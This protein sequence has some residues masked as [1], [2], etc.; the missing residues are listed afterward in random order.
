MSDTGICPSCGTPLPADAPEGLCPPCLFR[1]GAASDVADARLTTSGGPGFAPPQPEQLAARFP[2][3]EISALIGHGGMGAV[4]RALHRKLDRPVALKIL[5]PEIGRDPAFAERFVR[6]ARALARLNHPCIVTVHDF[7][8]SEGLYYF[9]MEFVEGRNLRGLLA[10]GQVEPAL[11]LRIIGQICD[12]LSYAHRCGVVHRDIKPENVL[13]D[14]G[15]HVKIADFGLAK[16]L[17]Y[18]AAETSLTATHQVMGTPHYMAPEQIESPG[19]VDQRA[20]IY[21]LGVVFYEMLTGHL[22]L[23]RFEPPSQNAEVG[24]EVDRVVLKTLERQPHKRYQ[25]ASEVKGEVD[26]IGTAAPPAPK[27]ASRP[28]PGIPE[29]K[30][31]S[32]KDGALLHLVVSGIAV[33]AL[34]FMPWFGFRIADLAPFA[35]ASGSAL[36]DFGTATSNAWESNINPFGIGIPTAIVPLIGI[37]VAIGAVATQRAVYRIPWKIPLSMAVV[38]ELVALTG[39]ILILQG[40]IPQ[41]GLFLSILVLVDMGIAAFA[42]RPVARPEPK[43]APRRKRDRQLKGRRAREE[44]TGRARRHDAG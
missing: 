44:R 3:Y 37:L 21:S 2:Q 26:G 15:D 41:I 29:V 39:L 27:P 43:T 28:E 33:F 38:A 36:R 1:A 9:V 7:G 23:G 11:A 12:A 25:Q 19:E 24:E 10:A 14:D 34:G 40:G 32:P 16:L 8:E 31:R 5:P 18:S 6:E 42:L 13:L 4:Y 20:D 17:E 22:P 30:R 35:R